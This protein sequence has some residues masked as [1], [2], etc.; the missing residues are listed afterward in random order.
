[1][2]ALPIFS[3][4]IRVL[5]PETRPLALGIIL[6]GIFIGGFIGS[7]TGPLM[8]PI[9]GWRNTFVFYGVLMLITAAIWFIFTP[10]EIL[11]IKHEMHINVYAEKTS[12]W[13][14]RF[15]IIWGFSFFPAIWIIFTLAPLISFMVEE[16]GFSSNICETASSVLEASYLSWSIIIGFLAYILAKNK[17][18]TP[19]SVFS[20]FAKL[21]LICFITAFIGILI[22]LNSHSL[23]SL[24]LGIILIGVIQGTGPTFWS[25]PSTAYPEYLI[26]KAGYVL[27]LIS[28]SA[29]LIGP[30]V[31]VVVGSVWV[32]W[33]VLLV[34]AIIGAINTFIC[35]NMELPIER[36][37]GG[38][39]TGLG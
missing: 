38:K 31:N 36:Y 11:R 22:V 25:T 6:S 3:S 35:S 34:M 17:P 2:M 37:G 12:V 29:A 8:A 13:R 30:L 21:Q 23:E 19:R 18:G 14:D 20:V 26:V 28:N 39:K 16:M 7:Y 27:G 4:Q 15:T 32:K 10:R 5:N 9:I 33:L 1:M 24:L